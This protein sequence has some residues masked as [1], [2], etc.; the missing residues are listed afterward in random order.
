MRILASAGVLALA[1]ATN[2]LELSFPV[3]CEL[4]ESCF[5]QSYV[6]TDPTS[7]YADFTCNR[8]SYDGH[9]GTD[10]ALPTARDMDAGVA[11][12]AAAEGTVIGLR[13]GMPEQ[14][15]GEPVV[16]PEGQ[17]CGNGVL[18][19]H[20]DGWETQYCHFAVGSVIV[21]TGDP[22]VAGQKLGEVGMSGRTNYPHLHINVRQNGQIVDPFE[23]SPDGSCGAPAADQLWQPA[24][25]YEPGGLLRTGF[26]AGV[27]ELDTIKLGDAHAP[28]LTT[29]GGALVFWAYLFGTREG[30]ELRLTITGPKGEF[31]DNTVTFDRTHAL[32]FRAG[33]R[34]LHA[35][36]T[37][38]GAYE[39]VARHIRD[40]QE[41]GTMT[42][43]TV[44]E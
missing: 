38:P 40:G 16:F 8:L 29:A 18:I 32:A 15:P 43:R 44:L 26:A 4:G 5:I 28:T 3:D 37:E 35:A 27:P 36:N 19:A 14:R 10:I 24:L 41:T 11:V 9:K 21:N 1:Q 7:D 20:D 33:G 2:A 23:P 25:A 12:L 30:D 34:R 42:A 31:F 17:D 6:D 39:G 22:V 13:D